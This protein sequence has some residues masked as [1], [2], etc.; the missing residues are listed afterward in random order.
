MP[1]RLTNAPAVLQALV[2]DILW[3]MPNQFVF[4][5]I[6]NILIFSEMR[7]QHVVQR[8]LKS[9]L[10]IKAEKCEFHSKSVSFL[11]FVV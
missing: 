2:N 5:D 11:G 9:K 10:F 8:F 7:E 1:F 4:V 6:D 3:D